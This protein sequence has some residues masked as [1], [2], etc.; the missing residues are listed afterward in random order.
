M[1]QPPSVKTGW[2]DRFLDHKI[3]V[4]VFFIFLAFA[5]R[6]PDFFPYEIDWDEGTYALI[7]QDILKGYLPLTH[8]W[9]FKPP[10]LYVP[11]ALAILLFG[12]SVVSIRL[13]GLIAVVITAL[14]LK[15]IGNKIYGKSA[16]FWAGVL[17]VLYSSTFVAGQ[18]TMSEHLVSVPVI[19]AVQA[20]FSG[21]NSKDIFK[22]GIFLGLA[23]LMRHNIVY[24]TAVMGIFIICK[25]FGKGLHEILK[26]GLT[27]SAGVL[28]PIG[29]VF[30]IYALNG[31][32]W[33]LKRTLIDASLAYVSGQ[34]SHIFL[35]IKT[36]ALMRT[37]NLLKT[38]AWSH[39]LFFW[40][41]SFCGFAWL[42]CASKSTTDQKRATLF[43][44]LL[45]L[46]VMFTIYQTNWGYGH[47][48]LSL[49]PFM[50]LVSGALISRILEVHQ[51]RII[52]VLIIAANFI[53]TLRPLPYKYRD[54]RKI[55]M[56][57][58]VMK[59]F[60]RF[61]LSGQYVYFSYY[62]VLYW[63]TDARVPSRYA[64]PAMGQ[65]ESALSAFERESVTQES[66][67]RDVFS[68]NPLFVLAPKDG[69]AYLNNG[70]NQILK[71]ELVQYYEPETEFNNHMTVY[72]RKDIDYT[73][74]TWWKLLSAKEKYKTIENIIRIFE[75]K[76]NTA[77]LKDPEFYR[78]KIDQFV[79]TNDENT[80]PDIPELVKMIAID[81]TD[82]YNGKQSS[83][84][85]F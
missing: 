38:S 54:I 80:I 30:S 50:A 32:F 13:L 79:S 11:Y 14:V 16:G 25:K 21:E 52:F 61:N 36:D 68:K 45:F 44:F 78:E 74:A 64:H 27:F 57:H 41:V 31:Q 37:L 72:I 62:N 29:I 39:R 46:S 75:N 8:Y 15:S 19:L 18:A 67:M 28:I 6:L 3:W 73:S 5:I 12:K 59:Y 1:M 66:I 34:N 2:F 9:D 48:L 4:A 82:F 20:F 7:A 70:A 22:T 24:L 26:S 42:G 63:L 60:E 35:G 10:L 55:D 43:I 76:T 40:V 65:F 23:C 53:Y 84:N 58:V 85:K 17:H 77:I 47:Y 83:S 33:L 51:L 71:S 49:I 81:E 56:A 69:I